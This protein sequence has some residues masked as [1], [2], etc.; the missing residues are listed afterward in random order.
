[1]TK[2]LAALCA[3]G[4]AAASWSCGSST[5]PPPPTPTPAPAAAPTPTPAPEVT[6][7]VAPGP[8]LYVSDETGGNIV[9][10]DPATG[11]LLKRIAVGKRPRG[12]R[13]SAD[14]TQLFVALSGSPIAGPKVDVSKLPPAD[15]SADGIGVV[16]ITTGRVIRVLK[17]GQDPETFDLSADGKSVFVSNEETAEMS[18][19][20]VASGEV[21][22]RVK[23]GEEPEGVTLR[24]GGREVYVTSEGSQSVSII[25]TA[26]KTVVA[27]V[28]TE[29]RPRAIGF[30][31]DGAT[32]LISNEM[33]ASITVVDARTH[34]EQSLIK[35]PNATGEVAPSRPMGVSVSAD[36]KLAFVTLGRTRAV[37][38]LDLVKMTFVRMI[39]NVGERPWGLAQTPDG[40]TLFTA[41]G[42]SGDVSII[43]AA[44]GT[45]RQRVMAGG[46]P[47]GVIYAPLR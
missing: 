37:A 22:S 25:D 8:R 7:P 36:G 40:S 39:E 19:V 3:I 32:A 9:I 20:D 10:I 1:M 41:N 28:K 29:P 21:R 38:V 44:T 18:I 11:N 14:G 15:R 16:D 2:R 6:G 42:P 13:L 47:W 46:S 45:V 12:L 23:V 27:T 30:T 33:G 31:P 34:R 43:D 24:P 17:S 35:I 4:L 26:K 5:P